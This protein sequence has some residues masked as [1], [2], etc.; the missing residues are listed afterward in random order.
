ML[1]PVFNEEENIANCYD[2]LKRLL[3]EFKNKYIYEIIFTDNHSV[4]GTFA[5]LQELAKKDTCVKVARFSKNVGYQRSIYTGYVL[6]TGDAV[7]QIDCDLQDPPELIRDFIKKWEGGFAVVYGIRKSRGEF[8]ALNVIRKVFYRVINFISEDN[9]PLDAGEF[10]LVDKKIVNELRKLYDYSPY[11][12]GMVTSFGFEQT[13][14]MY[15][16]NVR[17]KGRSKFK[18]VH[19][20]ELAMDGIANHSTVPLRI[21]S[22]VGFVVSA[23]AVMFLSVY[24][25]GRI[26]FGQNWPQGF[27][28]IIALL[29]FSIGLSAL[30]LG[31][32]GEYIGRIY[33]HIKQRPIA[34][35]EKT[36]NLSEKSGA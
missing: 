35:I 1:I 32:L 11:I 26:F 9:L 18:A 22:F 30:F 33:Q 7:I 10:R 4:D 27:A 16:R 21:A 2:A 28:T 15:D 6:S 14:I 36:F 17:K 29:L 23:G 19:L 12:R 31:I 34:I 8:W 5:L 24:F 13:G 20:F 25:V 3:E